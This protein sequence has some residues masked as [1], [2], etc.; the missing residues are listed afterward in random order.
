MLPAPRINDVLHRVTLAAVW[1]S[2]QES[3]SQAV[4]ITTRNGRIKAAGVSASRRCKHS[5]TPPPLRGKK[6]SLP[7]HHQQRTGHLQ[8]GTVCKIKYKL[9]HRMRSALPKPHSFGD[10]R[11][12]RQSCHYFRRRG[13]ANRPPCPRL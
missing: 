8:K 11:T 13:V 7:D 5:L 10:G 12:R 4:G 9:L 3:G 1:E 6:R 2:P